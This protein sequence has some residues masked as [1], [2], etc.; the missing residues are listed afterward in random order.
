MTFTKKNV[1]INI[2][3]EREV[4]NMR[5]LIYTVSSKDFNFKTASLEK[6]KEVSANMCIPY[7][8]SFETPTKPREYNVKR[9]EAIRSNARA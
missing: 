1:I 4:I 2:S 7:S 3:N 6:A 8:I 9:V 5:N